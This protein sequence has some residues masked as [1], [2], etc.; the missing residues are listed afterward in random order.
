[1]E[2]LNNVIGSL[3]DIDPDLNF[4]S[5]NH[6]CE[7]YSVNQYATLCSNSD[8]F[9]F[10]LLNF[11]IRSFHANFDKFE[12]FL[13]TVNF[14]HDFIVLSETWSNSDTVSLT[15]ID[16]YLGFHTVRNEMRSG[17]ISVYHSNK[18]QGHKIDELSMIN[19]T[20]ESCVVNINL[21]GKKLTIFGI[22]RPHS[23]S[24]E[25]FI[26]MLDEML[27]SP[28]IRDSEMILIVGDMNLNISDQS[29]PIVDRY[30]ATLSSMF[31]LPVITKPT[32]FPVNSGEPST[33]DH[34]FIN[35][36]EGFCS[37]V[38]GTDITDHCPCFIFFNFDY[39][40][41]NEPLRKITFRP[42]N[43]KNLD[44]LTAKLTEFDWDSILVGNDVSFLW[45]SF[46]C[47][48]ND[49]Y[50]SCFPIKIKFISEKRISKPWITLEIKR[51]IKQKSEYFKLYKMGFISRDANNLFRN[52]TNS[53]ISKA[54][55]KYYLNLFN[56]CKTDMKKSWGIV[57]NLMGKNKTSNSI[58]EMIFDD[59]LCT[60]ISTITEKLN[61]FFSTIADKLDDSLPTSNVLPTDFL[62]RR[63]TDSFRLFPVTSEECFE[64]TRRLKITKTNL[65][66]IPIK[67]F[68]QIYSNIVHPF[69]QLLNVSF[70]TGI[71][72]D[73]FKTARITQIFK[74]GDQKNPSHYRPIASLPFMSKIFERCLFNRLTAFSN[75][76][77][78]LTKSQFGFR[79]NKST[80]NAL[81]Q[82]TENVYNSLNKKHHH[83]SILIDLK[84]AFDIVNHKI[85]IDK[86]KFYGIQGIPSLL[87]ESY[88]SNR[89]QF[90]KIGDH[91]SSIKPIKMGVPQGSIL[92]PLLFLFYINDLPEVSNVLQTLLFADDTIL[93]YSSP[94]FPDLIT[95]LNNELTK[96]ETW[97]NS[98]R[99]TINV[100]KTQ[101]INFS[102]MF[103]DYSLNP[104]KIGHDSLDIVTSCRYLGVQIDNKLTFN[105]H[106]KLVTGKISKSTG[107]L[108][109]IKHLL[110]LKVRLDYYYAFIYPYLSYCVIVWGG[111]YP[112][113]LNNLIIQQKKIIR[114]ISDAP[115]L[116][117]SSPLFH[118]LKILKFEDIYRYQISLYMHQSQEQFMCQHT[119]NTRN[120]NLTVPIFH[121]LSQTQHA[122]SF[123]GPHVWNSLPTALRSINN[124]FTF[125]RKLKN[126]LISSY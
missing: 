81:I 31:F 118:N 61:N 73:I 4:F 80:Y 63:C 72:P 1:M 65:D 13:E 115:Y 8:R 23:G 102:N 117:H 62:N 26:V 22:Y 112:S 91:K 9:K 48:L 111:T 86:L 46:I 54:K 78:L 101:V 110:P 103:Y 104:V 39:S 124:I 49:L 96:L 109:K 32:R 25:N 108:Y 66:E 122:V 20:I 67:V 51:L 90:L 10:K 40:P 43:E 85:L 95:T 38:V 79:K 6:E 36:L 47:K 88:L 70:R 44:L 30:F 14:F 89:K 114:I 74:S 57:N 77:S 119:R 11:N 82:L 68:Q 113:H 18:F 87:I 21:N 97:T 100:N 98:N 29:S 3:T 41:V 35:K 42:F 106:I 5:A 2:A 116:S 16:G 52:K 121:R 19:D 60:D 17:G 24:H 76:F 83:L 28:L 55:S 45:E 99:L 105:D 93:S 50:C 33:L 75:K 58:K 15:N 120:R 7:F 34:I 64:I 12:A 71:C 92:G 59:E 126:F 123:K 27:H 125:K 53:I 107:I 69:I 84:K 94:K 37:G 56:K